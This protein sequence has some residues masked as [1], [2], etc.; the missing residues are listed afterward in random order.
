METMRTV[1]RRLSAA[2]LAAAV[3]GGC[4]GVGGTTTRPNDRPPPTPAPSPSTAEPTQPAV[5]PDTPTSWGPTEGE[6]AEAEELVSAMSVAEKVATVLM[7]G[8]WGYDGEAPAPAEAAANQRM[9]GVDTAV[10]AVATHGF[11]GVFLRPEVIAD[12]DQVATLTS[13]LHAV[14]DQPAGLPLLVSIDQE[15][16]A[17]QR[18]QVGVD[19]V[20]SA[21]SVGA[22]GDPSYAREVARANGTSLRE[23][24]VTMVMAPVAD[25]DPTGGSETGSRGYSTDVRAAAS[26][27]VATMKGYLDVGIVPVVKHFPG[28]GSVVGDSHLSLPVQPKSVPELRATDLVP[29]AAAVRAGAP[30]VMTGHVAV[31]ALDPGIPASTSEAVVEGLL[32]D[33]LGFEGVVVTD[34]QGMG[35]VYARW[36]S[37]ESAVRSLLAGNDLVLNSP[38][39]DEARRAVARAVAGG[40]LPEERLDEAAV[41]V[42]ALRMYQQRL[43]G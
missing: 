28:L 30:V 41:R 22:T 39:P 34:S 35:P 33:E 11:G 7:P 25:V 1:V 23:L 12:A 21:A 29:F 40:R 4:A 13:Q 26:M 17:V 43:A 18:L 19:P 10:E 6:L 5:A 15:G 38:E 3:L 27:V 8:F 24:G 32:R 2:F 16:G 14:G 42:L 36:G 9:H 37:G 20:P 31:E